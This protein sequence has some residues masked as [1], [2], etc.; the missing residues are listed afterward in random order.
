MGTPLWAT[1]CFS[2]AAFKIL[3]LSLTLGILIVLRFGVGLFASTL[4]GTLH[5]LD[6]HVYVLHQIRDV[7]CHYFFDK[8]SN[9]LLF[10]FFFW[11]LYEAN[12]GPLE[13]VPE[14]AYTIIISWILFSSYSSLFILVV[15]C[16]LM[17]Q[18][19]DFI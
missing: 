16:F 19:I 5:F 9:F 13:V 6:L 7:F 14:A 3:S 12:V 11:H 15:F 8:F 18:I 2:L 1:N 17:F 10:L 4:F